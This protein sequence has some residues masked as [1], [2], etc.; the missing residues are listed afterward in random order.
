[1]S[2][3]PSSAPA[4]GVT[5]ASLAV[6]PVGPLVKAVG[7]PLR[8]E[9]LAVMATGERMMV[10]EIARQV[11]KPANLVAKHLAVLRRAGV[12]E[13]RQRLQYVPKRYVADAASRTLDLGLFV[14]RLGTLEQE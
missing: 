10:V 6:L 13:T 1:M 14:L 8:L 7:D 3:T 5:T 11:N 12:V 4:P 9:I 2:E